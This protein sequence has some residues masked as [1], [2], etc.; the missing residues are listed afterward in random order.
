MFEKSSVL[1]ADC[2]LTRHF[3][4]NIL[5]VEDNFD[6]AESLWGT[7]TLEGF[8]VRIVPNRNLALEALQRNIYHFILLDYF[9]PGLSA[10]EFLQKIPAVS[11]FATVVLI[12]AA[13]HAPEKATELGLTHWVPKPIRPEKLVEKLKSLC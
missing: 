13:Q 5:I 11:R 10:E 12:T 8:G 1:R 4:K 3:S 2:G 9:M 6:T 7:L